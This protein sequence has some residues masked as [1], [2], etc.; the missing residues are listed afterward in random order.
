MHS[1]WLGV[2]D[3]GEYRKLAAWILEE[4]QE[5]CKLV[6]E[7]NDIQIAI[8]EVNKW[9]DWVK[10]HRFRK[11]NK[12]CRIIP[13]MDPSLLHT[14]PLAIEFK[15][16]YLLVKSVKQR[17]FIRTLK[18]AVEEIES[19]NTRYIESEEVF[20]FFDAA[21]AAG[22]NTLPFREAFLRRLLSGDVKTEEELL[23]SRFFLPGEAVPNVVCFIQGFV[24]CP[25]KRMQEGWQAPM[26]IQDYFK[27]QFEGNQLTFLS[28]RKHLLMLLQVP[29][30]YGS[31][32]H[33][34]ERE[35]RILETIESLEKEYGIQLYIGVGSVYREPLLLHHSYKEACKARRTSPYER[36]QLRYFEDITMDTQIQK[37]ADYI[38][39]YC[40]EDLSIKQ[41]ADQINLSV[42][43]FSRIFKQETGR[44]FVEYVTFVRMQRAVWMLRHTDH[45][46]EAIAEELGYNTPNYFS[47]TFKKY[48][49]LSPRDYRAT[50]EIIFI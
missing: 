37:C 42:P 31:L 32:K 26:V 2:E 21:Q 17:I 49:G 45:T 16:T 18:R 27:K 7:E 39:Q 43:Y 50:E 20:Q 41:V 1:I 23:Q 12:N 14:T 48:V 44:S 3:E 33:W 19:E 6:D 40:T 15:L 47:G 38:S 22:R 25:A 8:I 11:R 30:E 28:Y 35:E 36:L 13:L 9:H 4:C 24:R 46:V 10:I 34:K 29:S 5:N